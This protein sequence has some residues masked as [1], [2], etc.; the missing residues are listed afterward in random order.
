MLNAVLEPKLFLS[1]SLWLFPSLFSILFLLIG[2]DN[3][4]AFH[5]L[6]ELFTIIISFMIFAVAW[7]SFHY[8]RNDFLAILGMGYLWV[9]TIDLVHSLAYKGMGIINFT[10]I[11]VSVDFWL[12]ARLLE[13]LTLLAAPLLARKK[14]HLGFVAFGMA[15]YTLCISAIIIFYPHII[16][17]FFIEGVGLTDVKIYSEYVLILIFALAGYFTLKSKL[18][19]EKSERT[20]LLGA[21]FLT[22]L[23][24]L[25]FTRY[26]DVYGTYNMTGHVIKMF[27]FWMLLMSIVR[28]N[29]MRP[30]L[31]LESIQH[32]SQLADLA[33]SKARAGIWSYDPLKGQLNVNDVACEWLGCPKS[34]PLNL[35]N[36]IDRIGDADRKAVADNFSNALRIPEPFEWLHNM[37]CVDGTSRLLHISGRPIVKGDQI[38][39]LFGMMIDVTPSTDNDKA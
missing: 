9:G 27:S 8:K 5:T 6:S 7:P 28:T 33:L 3:F 36:W 25:A 38:I 2:S 20:L 13:A 14:T 16:P 26:T 39:G 10:N 23:A 31:E 12:A 17:P 24:E 1:P 35:N 15:A 21:I 4:L 30:F 18:S 11:Y 32:K 37:R 29:L 19:I 22:I 34:K